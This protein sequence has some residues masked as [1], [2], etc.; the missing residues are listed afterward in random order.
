MNHSVIL[1]IQQENYILHDIIDILSVKLD[2]M[3]IE[4]RSLRFEFNNVNILKQHLLGVFSFYSDIITKLNNAME[5]DKIK[6]EFAQEENSLFEIVALLSENNHHLE[7]INQHLERKIE[8]YQT[9][10][11]TTKG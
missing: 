5:G 9:K 4:R 8:T 2:D 1:E 7:K 11:H 10:Q 6:R 3:E